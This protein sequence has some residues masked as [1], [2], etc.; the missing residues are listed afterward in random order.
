MLPQ[1][2]ADIWLG[3]ATVSTILQYCWTESKSPWSR[4]A[5]M[6]LF[7]LAFA[8]ALSS[9]SRRTSSAVGVLLEKDS[10]WVI[11]SGERH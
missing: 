11:W 2:A 10:S 8:L 4:D 3:P 6:W 5:K 9:V 1:T 7:R